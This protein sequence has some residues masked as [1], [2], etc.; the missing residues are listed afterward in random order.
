MS[1]A[2]HRLISW[3]EENSVSV[4][5]IKIDVSHENRITKAAK[6][7]EKGAFVLEIPLKLMVTPRDA[8]AGIRQRF[9]DYIRPLLDNRIVHATYLMLERGNS[10]SKYSPY[11][12]ALPTSFPTIPTNYSD[13]LLHKMEPSGLLLIKEFVEQR[14]RSRY[15]SL[16]QNLPEI[17]E[18]YPYEA[19]KWAHLATC[20]RNFRAENRAGELVHYHEQISGS[21]EA[22][23]IGE[24]M[25]PVGDMLNHSENPN[26]GYY[27][28]T[29]MTSFVMVATREINEGEELTISY[30]RKNNTYVLP[31]RV[32]GF[33]DKL[34][35]EI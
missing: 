1:D 17:A 18:S 6:T 19:F 7:I 33:Y 29:N 10:R 28:D 24:L 9:P 31:M 8:L 2:V 34:M 30:G 23:T 13:E 11:I 5:A 20:S 26:V 12:D 21:G 27:V 4:N 22:E 32:R 16:C 25:V 3:F 14:I 15:Q 35:I